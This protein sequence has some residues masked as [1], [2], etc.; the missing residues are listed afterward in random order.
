MN[1]IQVIGP[2]PSEQRA[3]ACLVGIVGGLLILRAATQSVDRALLV[4]LLACALAGLVLGGKKRRLLGSIV[5][6]SLLVAFIFSATAV[7]YLVVR[8]LAGTLADVLIPL[9]S[10][11]SL[12]RDAL[13]TE[14]NQVLLLAFAALL[15]VSAFVITVVSSLASRPLL[16]SAAKLFAAGP[17][18]IERTNKILVGL[19]ATVAALFALWLAFG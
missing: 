18:A 2:V 13:L 16:D 4:L 12:K 15:F 6:S 9:F 10:G 14:T 11:I 3:L 17:E 8:I 5:G 19:A 7:T 1:E